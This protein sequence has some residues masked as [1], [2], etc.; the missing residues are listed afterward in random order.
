V[1][2]V[3]GIAII[4]FMVWYFLVA[5]GNFAA[6]LESTIAV[7]VIACPC[8][9]GLATP[10]SIMAGS[11][12]A[13]EQGVL[14]KTAE[15]LENTKHID[16]IVLDKTGTITNGRPVVTDFIPADGFD[17]ENLKNLAASAESQSEHPVAQAISEFG[18]ANMKVDS[19]KAV[20]GH[21]IR[22]AVGGHEVLMGN[23]RLMD[24]LAV[25]ET[26][27]E[28]MEQDGKTVMFM[29]VD[30]QYAGLIAVADTIKETAKQAIQEMKDMGLHV[31]MLTGDQERT[32]SAIAKQV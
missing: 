5:P 16:T 28:A 27:A 18:G 9:L 13:A 6:A 22:A 25:D 8:A 4:T 7:L 11:G 20:P 29:A 23:R 2:I 26:Q 24:G 12:R 17:L 32:A 1:P 15:S 19:F 14:F 31:V 10:T 30:G 3:V 21:G